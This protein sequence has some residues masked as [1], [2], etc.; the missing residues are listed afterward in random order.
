MRMNKFFYETMM[1]SVLSQTNTLSLISIALV[2]LEQHHTCISMKHK[3]TTL[4]GLIILTL[5]VANTNYVN[6]F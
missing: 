6:A 2:H 4:L 3:H 1:I 5:Y